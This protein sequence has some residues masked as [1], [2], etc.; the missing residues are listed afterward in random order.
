MS[1]NSIL[2]KYELEGQTWL[3]LAF[4]DVKDPDIAALYQ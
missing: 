2:W 4:P 3:E 1:T